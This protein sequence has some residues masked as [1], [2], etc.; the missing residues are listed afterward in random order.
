MGSPGA[1]RRFPMVLWMGGLVT[2]CGGFSFCVFVPS[3]LRFVCPKH[4]GLEMN[5]QATTLEYGPR[6]KGDAWQTK[7]R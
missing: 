4:G 1:A 6:E 3:L 7:T 2:A 5:L